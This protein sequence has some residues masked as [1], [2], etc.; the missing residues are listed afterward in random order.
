MRKVAVYLFL[1]G[2]FS[3][4]S[5]TVL[6]AVTP[7]EKKNEGDEFRSILIRLSSYLCTVILADSPG[8]AGKCR[9]SGSAV[10]DPGFPVEGGADLRHGCFSVE[11]Y[12]KTKESDPIEG[13]LLAPPGSANVLGRQ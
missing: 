7:N 10:A 3:L 11:T 2:S 6:Y 8:S 12:A 1:V 4:I 13:A 9:T 5:S